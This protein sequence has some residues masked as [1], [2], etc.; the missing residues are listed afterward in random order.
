MADFKTI[1]CM[2]F[3]D[4]SIGSTLT[5]CKINQIKKS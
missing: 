5:L 1:T 3:D 2:L 4:K